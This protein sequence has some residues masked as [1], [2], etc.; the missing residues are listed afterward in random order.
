MTIDEVLALLP[1]DS[2][3]KLWGDRSGHVSSRSGE[4]FARFS[5]V[6]DLE[7]KLEAQTRNINFQGKN[8]RVN[9]KDML[10]YLKA[11]DQS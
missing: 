7:D 8:F 6:D 10:D 4:R 11:N 2:Y 5:N 9:R 3:I 1:E